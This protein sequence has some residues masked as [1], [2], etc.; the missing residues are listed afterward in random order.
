MSRG[1]RYDGEQKLNWKKVFAVVIAIAVIIMF[2]VGIKKL[3]TPTSKGEEK[4]VAQK[5]LPVYTN[6]K[7]G[8]ID[9]KGNIVIEP[10]YDETIIIPDS[11]KAMFICTY[12]VNYNKNTYKTKVLNEKGEE[13]MTGYD[14]V[15]AIEN[16]DKDN[17]LW[18]EEDVLKVKKDGKYGVIDFKGKTVAD[19][20]YDSIDAIKGTSNSLITVKDSKKGLI[21]NTGAVI[22]DNEYKNIVAISDKYENGYIVQAQNGKYGVINCNKK[23]ALAAKY[24]DVKA[25]YGNGIYY[26]VKENG[27]W[28]IIDTDGTNYLSGKFDDVKSINNDYAVV[29]QS[30]KY[31]V[32]SITDAEKIIDIKYQDITYATDSNY[33]VKL[34]NKYGIV[35]SD[36]TN[37]IDPKYKNL[38]YRK[39]ANFYEGMN[40]DY[41]SDLID[42]DMNVKLTGII[43]ELNLESGYMKVRVGEEYQYYNFKFEQKQSKE[44]LKNNTIFLSKKDGKYGFVDKNGIVVVDYI[45]DDATEQNEFGYASVKKDGLW[46]CVDSKGNLKITPAYKLENNM[47]IEFIGKW[48]IG[49]DLNLNYYTDK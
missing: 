19:C 14:T 12:D 41:T 42:S 7:W 28:K 33:I 8:V 3:M 30:G 36:G 13:I 34:N 35:S 25:I 17:T 32:Y 2:V 5:Y 45:Y 46:G 43:S 4:V 10:T 24:E 6:S 27:K 1:K 47:L 39:D 38:V 48:H 20:I 37:L 29:K 18:Y 9:S 31:G 22:I 40:S 15:E 21:D 16:Y 44:A 26:V 49:E 23:V 11:T